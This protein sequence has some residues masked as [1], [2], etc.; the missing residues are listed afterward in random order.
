VTDTLIADG[1]GVYHPADHN[2][3]LLLGLSVTDFRPSSTSSTR[4]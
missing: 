2:C 4:A 3:R 1:D